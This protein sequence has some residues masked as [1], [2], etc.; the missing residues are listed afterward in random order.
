[1]G[2]PAF[3]L[4][5]RNF[6]INNYQII[7]HTIDSIDVNIVKANKFF[8]EDHKKLLKILRYHT[9]E[10]VTIN[11]NYIKKIPV[12]KSGKFRFIISKV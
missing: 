5:F 2:G 11:T 10:G 4:I 12:S 1:M 8:S 9:G 7:Q 3:T 6:K